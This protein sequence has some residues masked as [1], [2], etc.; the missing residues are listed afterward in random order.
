MPRGRGPVGFGRGVSFRLGCDQMTLLPPATTYVGWTGVD[1]WLEMVGTE[2]LC[3]YH[4]ASDVPVG[5]VGAGFDAAAL[6][7]HF[8]VSRNNA[9][10]FKGDTSKQT[11]KG[12]LREEEKPKNSLRADSNRRAARGKPLTV[13]CQLPWPVKGS[14]LAVSQQHSVHAGSRGMQRC[15]YCETLSLHC[16]STATY[17]LPVVV[18]WWLPR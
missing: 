9:W 16:V 17:H 5:G 7:G 18:I 12:L 3:A 8:E 6:E 11:R 1:V 2:V 13:A 14:C 4:A 15:P 10:L